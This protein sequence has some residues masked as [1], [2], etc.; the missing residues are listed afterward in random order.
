[1]AK[2]LGGIGIFGLLKVMENRGLDSPKPSVVSYTKRSQDLRRLALDLAEDGRDDTAAMQELVQAAGSHRKELRRAAA[3][4]RSDGYDVEDPTCHQANRLLLAAAAG[5]PPQPLTADQREWFRQ[6]QELRDA[7]VQVAFAKLATLEPA[8][9]ELNEH[10][11]QEVSRPGFQSMD[12]EQ[13]QEAFPDIYYDRLN[14][15]QERTSEPLMRTILAF[16]I[17]RDHLFEVA[18]LPYPGPKD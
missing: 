7:P 16:Y 10:V 17:A 6:V 3:S 4:I 2:A 18:G 8:L 15:I 5:E 13:R 14:S 1:M 12:E 11:R 9:G